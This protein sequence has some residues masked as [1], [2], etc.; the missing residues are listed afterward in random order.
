VTTPIAADTPPPPPLTRV[1]M[2]KLTCQAHGPRC[3]EKI[4]ILLLAPI[5]HPSTIAVR[6]VYIPAEG[7]LVL[8]CPACGARVARI[9]V[10]WAVPS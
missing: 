5:C 8:V 2:D 3:Q 10:A 4:D 6:A 7:V 1:D 9:Q